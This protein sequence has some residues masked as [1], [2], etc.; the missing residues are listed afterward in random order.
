MQPENAKR[1][2]TL[3][4]QHADE[5]RH[6]Y[7]YLRVVYKR[8]W[9]AV[10][11]F[12]VVFGIGAINS[13]R[14]TPIYE[15]RTQILIEKDAPKVGNLDTIFQERDSWY[16]DDFYQ[17]QY[18]ILQSRTLARKTAELMNLPSHPGLQKAR[19]KPTRSLFADA[20]S[21]VKK[22]VGRGDSD[23][24]TETAAAAPATS[25]D[26]FAAYSGIVLGALT[27]AP[28]RNSRL[29]ELR[30]M[31]PDP[32]L[33][34]D[35]ANAHAK[36]YIQHNLETRF[37]ASKEAADWLAKQLA[38]QRKLVEESEAALQRYKEQHDAVA[39]EDRQNIV[40]QRLGDLNA[41]V[42]RAKTQ[43]IEKEALYTQLKA[44][45]GTPAVDSFPAVVA[46]EYIQKLKLDLGELQQQHAQ[47]SQ[48]YGERHPEMIRITTAIRTTQAKYDLEVQK[49]VESVRAEY[50]AALNQER[51]LVS[52]L[53]A[54]K[55]EALGLNRKGIEY[56]VLMR[57]A[58]SNRQI[59]EALLQR[60][61]ETGISSELR[62]SNIRVI[63]PA[64]VPGAPVLPRR[65]RDLMMAAVS[66][67]ILA[68]GLVFLFEY[69]DNRIKSPQ[70]LRRHLGLPFLGMV[71]KID[72]SGPMLLHEGAPAAFAEAIRSL[73]TNVLFS[74]AEE[75]TRTIVVTS[76]GP[77]EGK[78]LVSGNLA[79]SLAQAGQ[80]VLHIDADMRR[81]RVHEIFETTQEPGLSNLLVGDCK[82]SEAVR[83]TSVQN[84]WILPAGMIPPNPAE[85]LGSKRC[86][87][88]FGRLGEHF[89]W[90]VI[91]SP[92]IM[93][94]ADAA[95]LANSATGVV[96]VVGSDQTSRHSAKAAVEQLE[97]VGAH[98]IGAVLNRADV[99]RNPYYY[100][101][102][103][104]KEYSRYYAKATPPNA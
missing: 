90:I 102:Y 104:R 72:T 58:E 103:Y 63:D 62:T 6:L 74:S 84:L 18:R 54:Q 95:I 8:R 42:T 53:E 67:A 25:S 57:D 41:A 5:E 16:T 23:E 27:V 44:L 2:A 43:R 34:A 38:E 33:A 21:W 59:Y 99:H 73:R 100:S 51:S 15:A 37:S 12:L 88:Y 30:M 32:Q 101:A 56:S 26:P 55:R 28:V 92:P 68:L 36:A 48:K 82:P 69:L 49:I 3:Q 10:P 60:T 29:V 52:A 66:G 11:V 1:P 20:L 97:S 83:K 86:Q 91:D 17:T 61:K 13:F 50:E 22:T 85:L 76:A 47:L 93:A 7:D 75:G 87:E 71:P 46:N 77:G 98:I 65:N 89:D 96:F 31:S 4:L 19:Q 35:L 45:Q 81:P 14:Q 9:I 40:V 39:V 80:R 79:V 78:S 94:V 70:E 64:E 24:S